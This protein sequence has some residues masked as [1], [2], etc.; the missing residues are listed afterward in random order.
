MAADDPAS[1]AIAAASSDAMP[2]PPAAA[3]PV[4]KAMGRA[5]IEIRRIEHATSRQVTFSKRRSGLLKK[6]YELSVLCDADIAVIMFSPTGKLFEYAN[7]SIEDILE[8]YRNTPKE[9]RDKRKFDNTDYLAKES[10]KLRHDLEQAKRELKYMH[11]EGLDGLSMQELEKVESKL[12]EGLRKLR[13]CKSNLMQQEIDRLRRQLYDA[14]GGGQAFAN[15]P[16]ANEVLC[17]GPNMLGRMT[18]NDHCLVPKHNKSTAGA[19]A[20][21]T[22]GPAMPTS[23]GGGA[24]RAGT[25]RWPVAAQRASMRENGSTPAARVTDLQFAFEQPH[26]NNH[27]NSHNHN[28]H[29]GNLSAAMHQLAQQQQQQQQQHQQRQQQLRQQQQQQFMHKDLQFAFLPGFDALPHDTHTAAINH[30]GSE[31]PVANISDHLR[32]EDLSPNHADTHAHAHNEDNILDLDIGT[33][34]GAASATSMMMQLFGSPSAHSHHNS[35]SVPHMLD[36]T[37]G[38]LSSSFEEKYLTPAANFAS[39]SSLNFSDSVGIAQQHYEALTH[40]SG[41]AGNR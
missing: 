9:Y 12:E 31:D 30:N 26:N 8:R 25:S 27:N 2:A 1:T 32:A 24:S 13:T 21:A 39:T 3:P 10:K 20:A 17:A 28:V 34:L 14:E 5:K 29:T 41:S 6:A 11:G 23:A 37:N 36:S 16:N 35:L 22:D 19:S 33:P 7:S 4:R 18:L 38:L 40:A 15:M